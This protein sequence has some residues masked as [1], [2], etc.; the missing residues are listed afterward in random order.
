MAL[1]NNAMTTDKSKHIDIRYHFVREHVQSGAIRLEYC[2][3]EKMLADVLTKAL[4]SPRHKL[5][6]STLMGC[7][8]D[9]EGEERGGVL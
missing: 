3:S 8:S 1:A 5:L 2:P 6:S 9:D 7:P 4:P